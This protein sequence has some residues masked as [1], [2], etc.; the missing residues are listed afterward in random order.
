MGLLGRASQVL[1]LAFKA[2]LTADVLCGASG[3]GVWVGAWKGCRPPCLQLCL[4]FQVSRPQEWGSGKT[5][6]P[7]S[8]PW[9][10]GFP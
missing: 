1:L 5:Q 3:G 9:N 7:F 8:I 6:C 4:P 2:L 10:S